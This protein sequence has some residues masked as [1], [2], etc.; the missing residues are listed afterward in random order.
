VLLAILSAGA[1]AAPLEA[2]LGGTP[3]ASAAIGALT[4]VGG[5]VLT[6]VVKNAMARLGTRSF[7]ADAAADQPSD[8]MSA[9]FEEELERRIERVLQAGGDQARQLRQE[10]AALLE[11][12][13][14]VGA[15]LQEAIESGDRE[16]QAQLTKGLAG[17]GR[18]FEE[19]SLSSP[20]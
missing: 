11:H 6:D 18:D 7:R 20:R 8:E 5:N 17:L 16:L 2:A 15:A 4:G 19:F 13:G 10:F 12:S 9:R 3:L 1:F 14:V